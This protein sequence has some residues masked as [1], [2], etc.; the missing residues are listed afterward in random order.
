[1]TLIGKASSNACVLLPMTMG[2]LMTFLADSI[3]LRV[4]ACIIR[5]VADVSVVSYLYS[6]LCA[7]IAPRSSH[8]TTPKSQTASPSIGTG[9]LCGGTQCGGCRLLSAGVGVSDGWIAGCML[10]VPSACTDIHPYLAARQTSAS[11][12]LI[13][14]HSRYM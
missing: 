4:L 5:A 12:D 13:H 8:R 3:H 6:Y 14:V 7:C 11:S 10:L 1:M 2:S 9:C